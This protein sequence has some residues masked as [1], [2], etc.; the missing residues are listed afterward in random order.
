[1]NREREINATAV[2]GSVTPSELC[3]VAVTFAPNMELLKD[4]D[5][6]IGNTRATYDSTATTFG[7]Y[8]CREAVPNMDSIARADNNL[9]LGPVDAV[10]IANDAKKARFDCDDFDEM[11][12]Y[13]GCKV[14]HDYA[15]RNKFVIKKEK[16]IPIMPNVLLREGASMAMLL[17]LKE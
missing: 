14:D 2:S 17:E 7:M 9:C 13:V 16:P 5:V 3:A 12:E 4:S 11:F 1:M 8:E 6:F 15:E 10:K